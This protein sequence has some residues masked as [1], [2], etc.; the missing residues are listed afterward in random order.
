MPIICIIIIIVI[1]VIISVFVFLIYKY[2]MLT[3]QHC[4]FLPPPPAIILC[5][6]TI[7]YYSYL[8]FVVFYSLPC[9]VGIH[10]FV[11]SLQ[12]CYRTK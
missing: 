3:L 12:L 1:T 5:P 10:I 2:E 6:L 11:L 8:P 9:S 4:H 7:E